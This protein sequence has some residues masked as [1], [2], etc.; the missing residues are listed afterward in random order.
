[1]HLDSARELK[2]Q[3]GEP[4]RALSRPSPEQAPEPSAAVGIVPAGE[5]DYRLAVRV[6]RRDLLAAPPLDAVPRAARGEVDVRYI[7]RVAKHETPWMR[8]RQRPLLIGSS[9]GHHAISAGT[10]GGFVRRIGRDERCV[11][12][13][14]HVLAD[15]NRAALGDE[16]I[17]PGMADGGRAGPDRIGALVD[18]AELN[19][20]GVNT[21]DCA[22]ALV[23]DGIE[24]DSAQ[25]RGVGTLT[26]TVPVEQVD[27]VAKVGRTTGATSGTVTA[28]E[29]DNV[30]VQYDTGQLRF[31]DQIE[32]SGTAA[33]AFSAGG[34]SGSLIVTGD[35]RLAVGL[36]FAG[37]DQGGP[38]GHGVTFA[39][40]IDAVLGALEAEP[41]W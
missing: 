33:A 11:L 16:V 7:G 34:D 38:G 27:D 21:V 39:N 24:I 20:D 40:P 4:L 35:G 5:D 12:S 6:Q 30:V 17:Q 28:F 9:L 41:L 36:L 3:L 31:D 22:L 37:S 23:D 29:V 15:E 32:I 1:M 18:F 8:T 19:P 10:L 26:G 25:V 2:H 14:N 13:N